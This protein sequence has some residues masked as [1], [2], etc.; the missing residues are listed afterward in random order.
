MI[1]H[2]AGQH[3]FDCGEH[4]HIHIREPYWSAYERYGWKD[5]VPGVSLSEELIKAA[6]RLGR[7]IKLTYYKNRNF[8]YVISPKKWQDL[9][10]TI[11][12][13]YMAR[14]KTKLLTIPVA[15]L[16][17]EPEEPKPD[18]KRWHE[19]M[20]RLGERVREL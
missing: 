18:Q 9:A 5:G 17:R 12:G 20:R 14:G 1:R 16:K 15:K 4:L 8:K 2:I 19:M 6:E 11:G 7:K 10:G 13:V 3:I